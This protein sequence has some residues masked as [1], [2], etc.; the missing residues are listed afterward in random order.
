[1]IER[2]IEEKCKEFDKLEK[3]ASFYEMAREL[4]ERDLP[5]HGA[6]LL[7]STWNTGRFR[8]ANKT[9]LTAKLKRV[10]QKCM[11][12]FNRLKEQRFETINLD[13]FGEDIKIIYEKLRGIKGV[14]YTGSTKV[15][16][17]M[18][19]ELFVMWDENIR[20]KYGFGVTS[21]EYLRFMGEMQ[22]KFAG[23]ELKNKKPLAK[24]IDEYNYMT[25]SFRR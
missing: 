22:E 6:I 10:F 19:P 24:A 1:M 13:F 16:S 7:L 12:N 14:E 25:I 3:R 21:G 15:M 8:Y 20:G 23:V 11:D 5:V 2:E 9:D 17:I 4:V 18:N